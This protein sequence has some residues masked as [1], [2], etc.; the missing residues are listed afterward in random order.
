MH[1]VSPAKPRE[2]IAITVAPHLLSQVERLRK[3]SGESRSAVFE[4]A[5]VAYLGGAD[6]DAKAREYAEAYRRVPETAADERAAEITAQT[7]FLANPWD[8]TR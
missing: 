8:A 6:R 2:K 4:R 3:K 5:L 7:V 1:N